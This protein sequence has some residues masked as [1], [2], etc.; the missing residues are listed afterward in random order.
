MSASFKFNTY[1]ELTFSV[2]RTYINVNTGETQV[3]PFYNQIEA[4]RL[5]Y[6]E[7][8]G[9]FEIQE[10][11]IFSDGI[12]EVKNVTA[13]SLEYTL[14][15]KYLE[16]FYVNTGKVDSLEVL[17]AGNGAIVPVTLYN[18]SEPGLSLLDL[19][20]QKIYGWKIGHVDISLRSMSRQFEISR[21]SVYDFIVQ[22]ICEKFNCF[23]VFDTI[24]NTINIYAE[25]LI[26][27]HI[28]DGKT[29]TFVVSPPYKS[30][31]TVTIDSY[32]TAEYTYD[33]ITGRLIFEEPPRNGARIE[34]TDGYQEQWRT[35][36]YVGFDNL[37]QEVNI[38][39]SADDIKTVLTVKGADDLDIREVNMGLPYIID[40]SYYHSVDWMGQDLYDKYTEYLKINNAY[41]STYTD[42]AKKMIECS[43]YISYITDRLTL[44]YVLDK[45]VNATTVGTYYVKGGSEQNPYYKEVILPSEYNV[46]TEYYKLSDANLNEDNFNKFY[47]ALKV[48]FASRDTKDVSELEKLVED[49]AFV[50]NATISELIDKLSQAKTYAD[51]VDAIYTFLGYMWD[52]LGLVPLQEYLKI[53]QE[54][55]TTNEESGWNEDTS[56]DNYLL[57]YA[58]ALIV[59][60]LNAEI[61]NRERSIGAYQDQYDKLQDANSTIT[62]GSSLY[63]FFTGDQLARLSAFLRE[64]EYTDDNFVITDSDTINTIIQRKQELREC[65]RI[66]LN[67]LCSPKLSFSMDMANIYALDE[68]APLIDQFQLGNLIN[69]VVRPDYIKRAR[70]L[71]VDINFDD[72][73]D[74]S[75]EFGELTNLK[76]PSSIHADLLASALTAGKSVASNESHWNQS[77]DKI[78]KVEIQLEDA[79]ANAVMAVKNNDGLQEIDT[80]KYGIRL[81]KRDSSGNLDPQEGWIVN[82]QF[83]YSDDNFK[84]TKTVF[85]KYTVDGKDYWGLVADAV[86][87]GKIDSSTITGGTI[88]I[89][90]GAFVVD[91]YGNVKM[92]A[93]NKIDGYT[94]TEETN[95]IKNSIT[96]K[97]EFDDFGTLIEQNYDHVKIAWNN[98]SKYISFENGS[99]NIYQSSTHADDTLLMKQTHTGAWY[100]R[101][102]VT[103]GHIGTNGWADDATFKGLI[104]DLEAT[105]DYM[106]WA[107]REK[108]GDPTYTVKFVYYAN[109]KK[110]Q[111]GLHFDCNTYTN[112]HLYLS[113]NHKVRVYSDD[114]IGYDGEVNFIDGNNSVY[115]RIREDDR[116]FQIFNGSSFKI[117]N[118]VQTDIYSHVYMHNFNL[119]DAELLKSSDA[120]LKTNIQDTQVNA[121]DTIMQI[122]MKEF[123]WIE[124][125]E[126]E[127]LGMIAQQVQT[128]APELVDE[129]SKTG[130]L[131]IKTTKFIP[132]LIKAVQELYEVNAVSTYDLRRS[133]WS[134]EY[135]LEDKEAFVNT[136]MSS[137]QL[138]ESTQKT[139]VVHEPIIIPANEQKEN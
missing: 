57:Y 131:S 11:E 33:N 75:C 107:H 29:K 59:N 10:P 44:N 93:S 53:Y 105:G 8:F 50:K 76:T 96:S 137:N 86:L 7:D 109:D 42:N 27:K 85:G 30:I 127:D 79:L 23:A 120:R 28:G 132:Y 108:V 125:G 5:V 112:G 126:H 55:K 70:L 2:G 40:I 83:L 18:Q 43:D 133:M 1:S 118:D 135:S 89:G 48:Y 22:D 78:T 15:Q 60:S 119:Y 32:K 64:D 37:A 136:L 77:V 24:N 68:F 130:R 121:L 34:I 14:S 134:D 49:F 101:D 138:P 12:Q 100:Y 19:A 110:K 13:Y 84:T 123:D 17:H 69:V 87:A 94:T 92:N 111:S 51:M 99:L 58:V 6:L 52:E 103:V 45:S 25:A 56:S 117:S 139:E 88:N 114:S 73:S 82:N 67:K 124:S 128:I 72:F 26:S 4:L 81:Q 113:D 62:R 104:F 38:S 36:V 61:K 21:T 97:V 98:N 71:E 66:E 106:C 115:I 16:D 3:N 116:S 54:I 80:S 46:N 9:Y 95:A 39:Y 129:D 102:G 122:D 47:Q 31:D 91:R 63:E 74:F 20:L 65:G 90:N 35:D 41:Q